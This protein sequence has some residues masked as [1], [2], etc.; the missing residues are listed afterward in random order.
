V[1]RVAITGGARGIGAAIAGALR[2]RGDEV[3]V[4]DLDGDPRLD[5]TDRASFAAF[6]ERAG[7]ID[8]LVN[9]AGVLHVGPFV[10]TPEDW[11]RRQVDINLVAVITGMQLALPRM[12][13]RGSGHIVNI[14]SSA[15]KIGVRYEA[16]YAA[17]KHGVYGLTESLAY[18]HRGSGV[19]FTCVMPGIVRTE[20]AAGTG[21]SG[22]KQITPQQVGEAVAGVLDRPRFDLYVPREYGVLARALA[23]LPN[24]ARGALLRLVGAE[25]ATATATRENREA[26]EE[27]VRRLTGTPGP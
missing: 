26:Y 3:V 18:E 7:D 20:L 23:P 17:T 13:E 9:N 14:A 15:S 12:L 6:L 19:H 10:D 11:I 27:R 25:R 5:V 22:V 16:V 21:L 4:G 8:V 1:R 24:R 2:A